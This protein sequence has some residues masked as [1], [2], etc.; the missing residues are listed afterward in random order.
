[1]TGMALRG[2]P[3]WMPGHHEWMPPRL[4]RLVL[5]GTILYW[6]LVQKRFEEAL[7]MFDTMTAFVNSGGVITE[8]VS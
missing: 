1:M 2:H 3:E 6:L 8:L 4:K 5:S 7:K